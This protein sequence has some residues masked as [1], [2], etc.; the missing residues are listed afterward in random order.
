MR[1]VTGLLLLATGIGVGAHA[2]YPDT[3]EKH[4]HLGKVARVLAPAAPAA[5]EPT[6]TE[7]ESAR[8]QTLS[9]GSRLITTGS[10]DRQK[11]AAVA[12]QGT[13][14]LRSQPKLVRADAVPQPILRTASPSTLQAQNKRGV[15]E[16]DRWRL[17]RDL[18]SELRRIGCY[19]GQID[20][21]WGP[22]SKYAIRDFLQRVNSA[23][24]PE[25]PDYI[26]LSLLRSHRGTV[27]GQPC[28]SGYDRSS[29]GR[30]IPHTVTARNTEPSTTRDVT[31]QAVPK[32]RL[33]RS[34]I[35]P[36]PVAAVP[37]PRQYVR[38]PP[39]EGR[40]AVGGPVPSEVPARETAPGVPSAPSLTHS[41]PKK[42][43]KPRKS[44]KTRK[45]QRSKSK[46]SYSRSRK[47][48][49]QARKKARRRAIMRQA[50]GNM[51]D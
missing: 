7:T 39:L 15:S 23:L 46:K 31:D 35:V 11:V 44:S 12:P 43:T 33:V 8:I 22:G 16:A 26:M 14:L 36:A 32:A 40:M 42:T 4:V 34:S 1:S 19:H 10:I 6:E 27:C 24:P 45:A 17:V 51:F 29:S 5:T 21:A 30:C 3:L 38:R 49:S 37:A 13:P 48:N 41:E 18:Q 50:F 20:G 28:A 25:D 2:Y 47:Y 9:P